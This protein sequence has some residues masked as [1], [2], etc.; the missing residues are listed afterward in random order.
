MRVFLITGISG[1]GKTVFVKALEDLGYYCVDN[2]PVPLLNNFIKIIKKSNV[3]DKVAIVIDIR[4]KFFINESHRILKKLKKDVN[5]L[6]IVFLDARDEVIVRRFNE[7]RRKHPLDSLDI[8]SS[9][10][11]EREI[12][13]SFREK[14]TYIIDTTTFSNYELRK[15]AELI[16]EGKL[17]RQRVQIK[18]LSFGFKYG[19]PFEADNIFDVRFVPNPFYIPELKEKTGLDSEVKEFIEEKRVSLHFISMLKKLLPFMIKNYDREGKNFIV[20]AFGCTGGKH[21]SV[22]FADYFYNFLKSSYSNISVYHRDL[23]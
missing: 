5:D 12:L 14:A 4:D 6:N 18:I 23:K 22:Y 19:V 21:R 20:F 2:L 11:Q 16:A 1:A 17:E 7:T 15:K 3:Y 8:I 9:I 13:R 10:N